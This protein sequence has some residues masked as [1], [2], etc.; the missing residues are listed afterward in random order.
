[1]LVELAEKIQKYYVRVGDN[2]SASEVALLQLEHTYYK[3]DSMATAVNKAHEFKKKY[4]KQSLLHPACFCNKQHGDQQGASGERKEHVK[5]HPAASSGMPQVYPEPINYKE[6]VEELCQFIYNCGSERSKTRTLLCAVFH[7]ALHDRYYVAR[8]MFLISHVQDT[9]DRADTNTQI[10]Y[11]RALVSLGLSAFR[12][13][14]IKKAHDCLSGIC[15]GRVKELLAQGQ[16]KSVDPDQERLERRRQVPYHMH[17]NPDLLECC[18]LISA[19]LL[20]LPVMTRGVSQYV[21]SRHFRKYFLTYT[22][23]VFTGPPENTRDNV[24]SASKHL[25]GSDWSKATEL[26]LNLEV[27]NLLPGNGAEKIKE[28]LSVKV[29]EEALRI[30]LFTQGTH[31]ESITLKHIC[32]LFQADPVDARRTICKMICDKQINGAWDFSPEETLILYKVEPT[33]LQSLSSQLADKISQLVESNERL[34][35]PLFG[36][37]GYK[38]EWQGRDKSKQWSGDDRRKP[39]DR[40][41]NASGGRG[42]PG[43]GR[44]RGRGRGADSGRGARGS[45]GRGNDRDGRSNRGHLDN[46]QD[47]DRRANATPAGWASM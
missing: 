9:I 12:L 20:E 28:M 6:K 3:H 14:L 2:T 13:G 23:Q 24:L 32:E 31:Y 39:Y 46:R 30:Y 5:V 35:D 41:R 25:L 33:T 34:I 27:W 43:A 22:T 10:L 37:Y 29:K 7:N 44:N 17:I 15:T 26:L 47:A 40:H 42:F 16:S 45:G 8:D 21:I 19:M 38:D 18:H 4:G 11:N 1:M 36:V